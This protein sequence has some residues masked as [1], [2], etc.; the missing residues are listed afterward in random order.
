[1][2]IR[3]IFTIAVTYGACL[4]STYTL[5][6]QTEIEQAKVPYVLT[7]PDLRSADLSP[8]ETRL[9]AVLS[10]ITGD[11]HRPRHSYEVQVWDFRKGTMLV[12][13]LLGSRIAAPGVGFS[14][15]RYTSD[16][17]LL[18]VYAA[19]TTIF[20]LQPDD[21]E[22]IR[23]VDIELPPPSRSA[24]RMAVG[25]EDLE[26]R[27]TS[28]ETS[29]N[30]H[31]VALRLYRGTGLERWGLFWKNAYLGGYASVYDLDSGIKI[32][33]WEISKG[34][35]E[36]G[37]G[38]AWQSNGKHLAVA[39]SDAVPC[40]RG[41]GTVYLLDPASSGVMRQFRVSNLVGDIA[42]GDED[43]IYV[44]NGSC[45]GYFSNQAPVLPVFSASTGKQIGAFKSP[46]GI[47]VRTA[48][49]PDRQRLIA[50]VGRDK[51]TFRGL[52]D[53]LVG[54]DSK[55]EVLDLTTGH[56]VFTSPELGSPGA[57]P[58]LA[59]TL[60]LSTSGDLALV[61]THTGSVRIFPIGHSGH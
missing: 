30:G 47:R 50:Y 5:L 16:G 37:S 39:S 53:T 28:F 19:G 41:G 52:E 10:H 25:Y 43:Y 22:K 60:R 2:C 61:F 56:V 46:T 58:S 34:Y 59:P 57:W 15:I 6:A 20:V 13:K 7:I 14:A 36:G 38:L 3:A 54:V 32:N 27:V 51:M 8:D 31:L 23:S 21:L 1:M 24:Q 35:L 42:W 4:F 29:P 40:M 44:A 12:R 17:R 18:V 49:S 48:V 33:Q 55:F 26:T 11:P 45:P 9:A